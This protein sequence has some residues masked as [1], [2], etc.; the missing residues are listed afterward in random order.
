MSPTLLI[1]GG[2]ISGL[3]AAWFFRKKYPDAR[4]TLLEQGD[5]LGGCIGTKSV[6]QFSFE[7]G[8]RTFQSSRCQMLLSLIE[9][10]GLFPELLFSDPSAERRYLWYKGRLRT[11]RSLWPFLG[12]GIF[13]DLVSPKRCEEEESIYAFASRRFGKKA[14]EL[15]FDPLAKGV[16]GGD[17]RKL[18]LRACF[19]S[20]HELEAKNRSICLG[21][22]RQSASKKAQGLFTLRGG[23]GRLIE[24]LQKIPMQIHL[25]CE[26]QA[27]HPDF[28]VAKERVWS[29]DQIICALPG[30]ITAKLCGIDLALR[31]ETIQVVNLGYSQK[32]SLHGYGYLVPSSQEEE[33]LGQIWDSAIFPE[34]GQ[35]KLTSMVKSTFAQE[36]A[37]SAMRRHLNVF[38]EPAAM[39]S[40]SALIAQ[41]DVGHQEKIEAFTAQI[42]RGF[43]KLRLTGNYFLGPSVESCITRSYQIVAN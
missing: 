23:M 39:Y 28:V 26:V 2:G 37:L 30:A 10:V 40:V 43:P 12:L 35:T 1:L 25:G 3:S 29:A 15:F 13:W 11:I 24:A 32:K 14:A 6:G 36:A 17:I 5:R 41:Y 42:K 27:I 21:L 20:L 31:N 7:I 33:L 22:L 8:P 16:F 38:D 4:I 9:E 34:E 18:S 19:P